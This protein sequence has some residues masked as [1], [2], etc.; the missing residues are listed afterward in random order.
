ML[1]GEEDGE[2]VL[3][4]DP[5]VKVAPFKNKDIKIGVGAG[6]PLKDDEEFEYRLIASLFYHMP[7]LN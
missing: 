4:I 7:F 3:N 1:N 5:G 6:F 2:S